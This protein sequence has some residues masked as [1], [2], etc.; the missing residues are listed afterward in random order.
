M[1]SFRIN[2]VNSVNKSREERASRIH[3]SSKNRNV[4]M[5]VLK[6]KFDRELYFQIS[7][8]IKEM[9]IRDSNNVLYDLFTEQQGSLSQLLDDCL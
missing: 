5:C 2:S 1:D 7:K 4:E 9:C 6:K 8:I 3:P